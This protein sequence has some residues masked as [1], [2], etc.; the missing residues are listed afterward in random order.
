MRFRSADCKRSEPERYLADRADH[1]AP[2]GE[3]EQRL[4]NGQNLGKEASGSR[5]GLIDDSYG[6]PP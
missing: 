2:R 6:A 4:I 3:G 1:A 5:S